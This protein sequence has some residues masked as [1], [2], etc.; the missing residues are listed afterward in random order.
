MSELQARLRLCLESTLTREL[1][2]TIV[3]SFMSPLDHSRGPQAQE[4]ATCEQKEDTVR[5]FLS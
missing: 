3:D 2:P 4:G 1:S 5:S